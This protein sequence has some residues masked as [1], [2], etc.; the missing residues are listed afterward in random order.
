[1]SSDDT[2]TPRVSGSIAV[3]LQT[4]IE[5]IDKLDSLPPTEE[6]AELRREAVALQALFKSWD[7]RAPRSEDR[8]QALSR[9]M[10]LHRA[11]AEYVAVRRAP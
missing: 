9:L 6:S 10:D 11:V 3:F 4:A 7:V 1:M 2:P 8:A 5:A